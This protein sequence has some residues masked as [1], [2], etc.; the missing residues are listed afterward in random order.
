MIN[1]GGAIV[2]GRAGPVSS[3]QISEVQYGTHKVCEIK[4]SQRWARRP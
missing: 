2:A 4:D 3:H 1:G